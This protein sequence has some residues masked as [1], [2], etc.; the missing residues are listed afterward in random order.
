MNTE[1]IP[2]GLPQP[3]NNKLAVSSLVL[4][5]LSLV[6]CGIGVLFA[7]PGLICG[8]TGMS[9][10]KKSGGLEKGH[11]LA[12][13][14]TVMSGTALVMFPIIALLAAIAVPNFVKART[15]AQKNACIANL[16]QID[17]AKAN[18][19][20]DNKKKNDETPSASDLYG[21]NKYIAQDLKCPAGGV[22]SI[23]PVEE[24]PTCSVPGHA[25]Y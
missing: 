1:P 20:L 2:P 10:V 18:W 11:G 13:A 25:L 4:G 24:K 19:A 17:A 3:R 8:F 16:R 7:I 5:I 15:M 12:L 22:Y 9:R 6:L 14:G 21:P 23:N